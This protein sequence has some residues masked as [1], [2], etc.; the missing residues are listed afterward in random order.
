MANKKKK[1]K[2]V[3]GW[4]LHQLEEQSQLELDQMDISCDKNTH[5]IVHTLNEAFSLGP[6]VSQTPHY[7]NTLILFQTK[8]YSI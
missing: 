1:R 5:F 6:T 7:S 4:E 3:L 2:M 8:K